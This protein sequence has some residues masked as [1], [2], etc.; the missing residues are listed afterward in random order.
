MRGLRVLGF[1][2]RPYLLRGLE[3]PNAETR[4]IC[5]EL[6]SVSDLC[7]EGEQG[8]LLLMKL[9]GDPADFRIRQR[10]TLLEPLGQCAAIAAVE[11]RFSRVGSLG[12]TRL[13]LLKSN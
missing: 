12:G 6:L 9:S 2:G 8:R 10:G 4:R 5:L 1:R 7:A 11:D 13:S 3:H